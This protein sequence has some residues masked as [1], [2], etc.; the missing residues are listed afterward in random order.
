[1]IVAHYL[2]TVQ[3][4]YNAVVR[5]EKPFEIRKNDRK[6]QLGDYVCLRE[7]IVSYD[8]KKL[9]EVSYSDNKMIEGEPEEIITL[10]GLEIWKKIVYITDFNQQPGFVVF[11]LRNLSF[12]E[13]RDVL[14]FVSEGSS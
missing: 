2:K 13:T 11:A 10:T 8:Y 3:P 4:Y 7:A 1:M 6:F 9:T 12:E 5:G 14:E